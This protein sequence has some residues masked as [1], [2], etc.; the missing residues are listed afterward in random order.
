LKVPYV[1]LPGQYAA[2]KEHILEAIDRV[3]SSGQYILSNEVEKFETR[4]AELCQAKH[5]IGVANGTD[6]LILAMKV[7]GIGQG[8]EVITAPNSWISSASSIALCGAIPVFADVGEDQNL[9]P[10]SVERVI[11][12]RTKAIMPVHLTGR[13]APM[14]PLMELAKSNRLLILEDAAQAV[15]SKY[16][17]KMAGSMGDISSFSLHPL[18]NL[19]G[20]GDAG[21]L[22]TNNDEFANQ[23][24]LLRNHGQISRNIIT[25]W[26]FNSRLDAIQAAVLNYRLTI[27]DQIIEKRRANAALYYQ[28]LHSAIKTPPS[29]KG[30]FDTY[31]LFVIQVEKRNE[32]KDFLKKHQISTAIHYPTPLHLQAAC[33]YLGYKEGDFPETEKQSK[34]ILS[35]PVHHMLSDEQIIFVAQKINEF[36]GWPCH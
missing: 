6:S 4:F 11:T 28:H 36:Y 18:K 19:N 30:Y 15:G 33:A 9:D 3:L 14:N 29:T 20:C 27:L 10:K 24:K 12:K 8:D 21:I 31:H 1:D 16:H 35:I 17:D 32:L 34:Q 26:G 25:T 2:Q 7:M 23:L 22:T 5:A 13:I